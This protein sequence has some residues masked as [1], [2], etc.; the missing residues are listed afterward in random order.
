MLSM[1]LKT[2]RGNEPDVPKNPHYTRTVSLDIADG[3]GISVHVYDENGRTKVE[4]G[5]VTDT[6]YEKFENENGKTFTIVMSPS[7]KD[8]PQLR[9]D[10]GE[11]G[12]IFR[13]IQNGPNGEPTQTLYD[14]TKN[15]YPSP[16]HPKRKLDLVD[17]LESGRVVTIETDTGERITGL[18]TERNERESPTQIYIDNGI[19]TYTVNYS[20]IKLQ[21]AWDDGGEIIGNI[22]NVTVEY[23]P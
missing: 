14:E 2:K 23:N 17:E 4:R 7:G 6:F 1:S 19:T 9:S 21:R 10:D 20:G 11:E 15:I 8:S 12:W 13:I 3:R 16:K 18:V 5:V 22:V